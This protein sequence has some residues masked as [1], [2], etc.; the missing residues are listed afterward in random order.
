[1]SA[2]AEERQAV[3][4][5]ADHDAAEN[6]DGENDD[7]GDGVAA[8][9]LG[10]AVHRAEEG[11]FLLKLAPPRLRHL[12]IDEAGREVGVNRHLFS[13]NG[14][15]G[16]AR[17]N[18]GDAG[19]AL[20]DDQEVDRHQDEEDDDADDEVAAHHQ[21]GETADDVAR[22]GRSLLAAREDEAGGRNVQREPQDRRDQEHGRE[23]RELERFVDPQ[24]HHQDQ[25]GER[26]RQRQAEVDHESWNGEE[27]QAKN[28]DDADGEG[29]ILAAAVRHRRRGRRCQ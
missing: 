14:V 21:A 1:M 9:E 7:A 10:G 26:D 11:A 20:G 28:E 19:R 16:E 17:A 18:L 8:D 2:A 29:D 25:D 6:V 24:R 4:G 23:S 13:R 15:E 5:D 3:T 22:R 27:E 12:L